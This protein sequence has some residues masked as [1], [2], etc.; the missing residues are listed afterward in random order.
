MLLISHQIEESIYIINGTFKV[1]FEYYSC[2]QRL[3]V[4]VR[5]ILKESTLEHLDKSNSFL[6]FQNFFIV[7]SKNISRLNFWIE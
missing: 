2:M 5:L 7:L 6:C 3:V 4:R 1:F